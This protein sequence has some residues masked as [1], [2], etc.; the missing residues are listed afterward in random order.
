MLR[1]VA[2]NFQ[3]LPP[4]CKLLDTRLALA[5]LPYRKCT[6]NNQ[7]TVLKYKAVL[8]IIHFQLC[9]II[10]SFH[11]NELSDVYIN[12]VNV[13]GVHVVQ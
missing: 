3:H 10:H 6:T 8:S 5:S 13:D 7:Q 1:F 12:M 11:V 4:F 2:L 9:F